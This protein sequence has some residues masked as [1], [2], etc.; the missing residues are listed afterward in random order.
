[1][2]RSLLD[3]TQSI[4][5]SLN[6]DNVNSISDSSESLQVAEI[7]KNVYF[8]IVARAELPEHKKLFHLDASTDNSNPVLMYR[9]DFVNRIEW[10]KYY[11]SDVANNTSETGFIHDLNTDLV[12]VEL[13]SASA[14][15]YKEVKIIS[16]SSFLRMIN[17]FNVNESDVETFELDN[18][19]FNFK[20]AQP[21]QYCT[22]INNY[23]IIFDAYDQNVDST[24]QNNKT[25]CFGQVMP[26]FEM[27][28][29]FIP[30]LDEY[31][32]PLLLSEAKSLAFLE[33][34]QTVHQK[35]EQDSKRQWSN[36]QK[37]KALTDK[38]SA[39]DQ[40]PNFGRIS[41]GWR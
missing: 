21:P 36:L 7:I 23:S 26:T 14:P 20:N 5:S 13:D 4:L 18:M 16:P 22:V 1:M 34:K 35:A 3:L 19:K 12:Q 24:L 40:L 28:D 31:K 41:G 2:K 32:F 25:L 33:L 10:I 39:F 8:S 9:P 27:V 38:P 6:S 15:S 11:D 29:A 17:Q 37:N 30:E